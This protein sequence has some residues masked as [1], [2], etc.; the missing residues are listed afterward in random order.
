[1]TERKQVVLTVSVTE[2]LT[3]EQWAKLKALEGRE[4]DIDDGE[5]VLLVEVTRA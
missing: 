1:M 2:E 5:N 4:F 3:P